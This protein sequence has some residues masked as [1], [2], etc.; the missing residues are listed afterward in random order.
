MSNVLPFLRRLAERSELLEELKRKSKAEVIAA[1]AAQGLPF[2]EGDFDSEVWDLEVQLAAR[3]GEPFD[4]RFGL[5]QTMWGQYYL[6]YLVRDFL[7]S[8]DEA[9]VRTTGGTHA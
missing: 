1:A 2:A 9:G 7:T 4:Q 6:E 8:L 3:R 5:W